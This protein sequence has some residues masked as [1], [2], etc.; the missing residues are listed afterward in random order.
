[1]LWMPWEHQLR[2][3]L[4]DDFRCL[5]RDDDRWLVT[6]ADGSEHA[7]SDPESAYVVA[8]LGRWPRPA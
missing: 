8:L 1:V 7:G 6:L 4:G 2:L 3:L 5:Q